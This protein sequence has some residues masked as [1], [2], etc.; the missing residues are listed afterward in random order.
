MV[1]YDKQKGACESLAGRWYYQVLFKLHFEDRDARRVTDVRGEVVEKFR[2][3]V[4][5][6]KLSDFGSTVGKIIKI[7]ISRVIAM[8]LLD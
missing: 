8:N 3:L 6:R 7:G 4:A 1:Q 2:A 5:D